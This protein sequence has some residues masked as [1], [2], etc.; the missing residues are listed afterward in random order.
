MPFDDPS[1]DSVERPETDPESLYRT[2][3]LMA[4]NRLH[5]IVHAAE[6]ADKAKLWADYLAD[7]EKAEE[8]AAQPA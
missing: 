8:V 7:L 1:I 4:H 2:R 5:E 6:P 3:W